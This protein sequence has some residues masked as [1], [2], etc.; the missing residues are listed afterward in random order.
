MNKY[1]ISATVI[2]YNPNEEVYSNIKSYINNVD[3][4]Y[5]ID[6]S[7]SLNEEIKNKLLNM[8][9][10]IEYIFNGENLGI[11]TALNIA[12]DKAIEDGYDWILTMDQDSSF[13]K[14]NDYLKCLDKL[15]EPENTAIIAANTMWHAK[16]NIPLNPSFESEENFLVITSANLLNLKLFN[17][18]GRFEDK[19]FID[20]VDYDYCMKAN[21]L[22]YKIIYFKDILVEHSL[23]SVFQRRN[24][25]TGKLRTKI[26][27]SAQR[28]Y[29]ITRNYFYTWKQ[30][31]K[32]FPK[33]FNLL[34]TIN[35]MLI[36]NITKILLYEDNKMQKITSKFLGLWHFIINKFGR[37]DI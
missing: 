17:E 33:E 11:A 25:F 10:N 19:L 6:N 22:K 3:K 37:Y 15:K 18:I 2:F 13:L 36:H 5:I 24:I 12:C 28:N 34:K 27:H 20:M 29:Y 32:L 35:I 21:T 26:E 4:L 23:G 14:F 8:Y 7:D 31:N 1:K 30:Y 9:K 16:D